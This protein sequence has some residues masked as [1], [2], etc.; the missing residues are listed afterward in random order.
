MICNTVCV[1]IVVLGWHFSASSFQVMSLLQYVHHRLFIKVKPLVFWPV[2]NISCFIWN[3]LNIPSSFHAM[4]M[5]LS[6]K[7]YSLQAELLPFSHAKLVQQV[8]CFQKE[9]KWKIARSILCGFIVIFGVCLCVFRT[10]AVCSADRDLAILSCCRPHGAAPLG[11]AQMSAA[12]IHRQEEGLVLSSF[13][14]ST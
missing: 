14:T 6:W 9:K 4:G 8:S 13:I 5:W 12:D 1:Y 10:R 7:W 2:W 3:K 11:S